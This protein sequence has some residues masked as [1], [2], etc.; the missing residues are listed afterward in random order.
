MNELVDTYLNDFH[1]RAWNRVEG[2]SK[3]I[4]DNHFLIQAPI[5]DDS[6]GG[7]TA[8]SSLIVFL[9]INPLQTTKLD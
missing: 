7:R 6:L 1:P 8:L 2:A 4:T 9:K 5:Q 3:W